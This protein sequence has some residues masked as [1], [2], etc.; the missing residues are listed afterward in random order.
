[1]KT[2]KSRFSRKNLF[3]LV[4]SFMLIMHYQNC[5]G[6][7]NQEAR[8]GDPAYSPQPI[9]GGATASP[10]SSAN[11]TNSKIFFAASSIEL[12]AQSSFLRP[13]G[14]CSQS[15]QISWSFTD[16]A[17][18]Q[19]VLL[20]GSASCDRGT[21]HVELSQIIPQLACEKVYSL[22]AARLGDEST[23]MSVVRHCSPVANN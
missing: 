15:D 11:T 9:A 4:T 20:Q 10:V 13:G 2:H 6:P 18:N 7:V 14:I 19:V 5:A 12:G 23:Q 21:F 3:Y 16:A 22:S 1:M 8:S 17:V